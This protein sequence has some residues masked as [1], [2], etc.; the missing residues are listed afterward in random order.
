[1]NA[2]FM[3]DTPFLPGADAPM[4]GQMRASKLQGFERLVRRYGADSERILEQFNLDSNAL[5]DPEAFISSLSVLGMLEYCSIT[6]KTPLFGYELAKLQST[7]CFGYVAS[8]SL[9]A[10][11]MGSALRAFAEFLPVLFSSDGRVE[12]R[13]EAKS[14]S[15]RWKGTRIIG[16]FD[17]A[18]LQTTILHLKFLQLLAGEAFAPDYIQLQTLLTE[19]DRK[20]IESD[21]K[22]SLV[23]GAEDNAIVFSADMLSRSL[24]TANQPMFSFLKRQFERAKQAQA[25]DFLGRVEKTAEQLLEKNHYKISDCAAS[26]GMSVRSLQQR[27]ASY[28][29]QYTDILETLRE[30]RAR[31]YLEQG[32]AS[33]VDIAGELGYAEQ[34]SFTR[35]FKRWTGMTP[36]AYRSQ[37][38]AMC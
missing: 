7:E 22:C 4:P 20:I 21:L 27:L 17:Q 23:C 5:K 13:K 36:L 38:R 35:A 2:V 25:L 3:T 30:R 16:G 32:E 37:L 19:H 12:L 8:F 33:I 26:L 11:D 34:S 10:P 1:M 9:A 18:N 31:Q 15:L 6:F 29:V 14:A 28:S 24:P